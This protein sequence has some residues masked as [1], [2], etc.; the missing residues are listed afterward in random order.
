MKQLFQR[1]RKRSNRILFDAQVYEDVA[2]AIRRQIKHAC[3]VR[4]L[5]G[6][7]D[8][9]ADRPRPIQFTWW[10]F[11]K[12]FLGGPEVLWGRIMETEFDP[13]FLEW[14]RDPEKRI[15]R[16]ESGESGIGGR[17]EK[18]FIRKKYVDFYDTQHE[19]PTYRSSEME[20]V[21]L[22]CE[23]PDCRLHGRLAGKPKIEHYKI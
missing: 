16:I 15:E 2:I 22:W 3:M 4:K 12:Q 8:I 6:S 11:F 19:L 21:E 7:S 5:Y 1:C 18:T 23:E 14:E 13:K 9:R 10:G 20:H 17:T